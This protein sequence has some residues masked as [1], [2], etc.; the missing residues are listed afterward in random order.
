MSKR[1]IKASTQGIAKAK[2][3]LIRNDLNQTALARESGLSRS[4]VTN[5]FRKIAIERL[6]FEEI[7]KN[8]GLEWQEIVDIAVNEVNLSKQAIS[9]VKTSSEEVNNLVAKVRSQFYET[10]QQRCGTMRI[11]DMTQPIGLNNI[12]TDVNILE[13]ITG[14]RRLKIAKLQQTFDPEFHDFNRYG[15]TDI[16]QKRVPGLE[17]VKNNSKLMV[18]GKPGAGKTTFLKYLAI[19]CI[20]GKLQANHVPVFITLKEFAET[21]NHPNFSEFIAQT[22]VNSDITPNQINNLLKQGKLFFC[23]DGLD[24]VREED[25]QRVLRQIKNLFQYYKNQFVITCRIAAREYTFEEFTEVEVADFDDKQIRIFVNKWFNTKKLELSDKFIDQLKVNKQIKELASNPLLLTLLCLEFEDSSDFPAERAELYKRATHTLLRKWDAKRGIVREQVYKKLSV[26]RK[27]DLLSEVAFTTFD[28]KNYF[29][30]QKDIERYIADYIRNLPH[31][32]TDSKALELDSEAVLKSIEAQHGLFVERA[33]EI[34][35]FSHLTFQEYFTARKIINSCNPYSLS[36]KALQSLASHITESR[37]QEVFLMTVEMLPKAD[38]LLLLMKKQVD[39]IVANDDKLQRLLAWGNEKSLA[40]TINVSCYKSILGVYHFTFYFAIL[41]SVSI[42]SENI[43][44]NSQCLNIV[45][46]VLNTVIEIFHGNLIDIEIVKQSKI[47]TFGYVSAFDIERSY[48]ELNNPSQKG[49]FRAYHQIFISFVKIIKALEYGC[50]AFYDSQ[51][52]K[53]LQAIR[54]YIVHNHSYEKELDNS[55]E[56]NNQILIKKLND[57][58]K[59][60]LGIPSN[61]Q[62]NLQQTKLLQ[63]YLDANLLLILC[64]KSDA[65]ITPKVRSYIEETLLLPIA[66]I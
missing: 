56:G 13:K 44:N 10:I 51:G 32:K 57:V 30:K 65:Y 18:L 23:L 28:N 49:I 45:I 9:I 36:D 27:E 15:L 42:T 39:E 1:G 48:I 60:H 58:I 43:I 5:F 29:F 11:L 16:K 47:K 2:Q 12:Y 63:Q 22:F 35:S 7:C 55:L 17:A 21:P 53:E 38:C 64:L 24:E 61:L 46:M 4:T 41:L 31:A 50:L 6:N 3:A 26:Q 52:L 34:Y 20:R 59:N 66:E 14:R 25:I 8:L 33:R 40:F 37:W 19:Q 54:N 62:F